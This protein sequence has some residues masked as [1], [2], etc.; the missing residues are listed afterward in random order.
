MRPT[1]GMSIAA[2]VVIGAD[3]MAREIRPSMLDIWNKES[4]KMMWGEEP[5]KYEDLIIGV[6]CAIALFAVV[7]LFVY[8]L[9]RDVVKVVG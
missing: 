5:G 9:L 4:T 8:V 3:P 6:F 1:V 2:P 7:G